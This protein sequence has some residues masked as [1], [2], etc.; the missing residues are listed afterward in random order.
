ME[1]QGC[2]RYMIGAGKGLLVNLG[3]P[4]P[5]PKVFHLEHVAARNANRRRIEEM[6]GQGNAIG[7]DRH[8]VTGSLADALTT[9]GAVL[10]DVALMLDGLS[11]SR[12]ARR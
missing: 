12:S 9:S 11:R 8:A 6:V 5:Q 2:F 4:R 1:L 3:I 7:E 10:D